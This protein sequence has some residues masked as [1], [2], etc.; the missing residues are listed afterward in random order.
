MPEHWL[1]LP[2]T[3]VESEAKPSQVARPAGSQLALTVVDPP[4]SIVVREAV[5]QPRDAGV[6]VGVAV[7][8]GLGVFVAAGLGVFVAVGLGVFVAVGLGVFVAVGLGVGVAVGGGHSQVNVERS[9]VQSGSGFGGRGVG[10]GG[11]GG[12]GSSHSSVNGFQSQRGLG[13]DDSS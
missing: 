10:V 11:G 12:G 9:N 6:G 3:A 8:L 5:S 7:G 4:T 1:L 2:N 13:A